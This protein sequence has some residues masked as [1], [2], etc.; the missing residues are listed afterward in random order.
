MTI[1][2]L[3]DAIEKA[4]TILTTTLEG[5]VR[6]QGYD[7]PSPELVKE[8]TSIDYAKFRKEL[9]YDE[10]EL[11]QKTIINGFYCL[12]VYLEGRP[13]AFDYGYDDSDDR[14]FFSDTEATMIERKGIGRLLGILE[15]LY[16]YEKGYRAVKFMTEEMDECGRP[17]REIWEKQGYMVANRYPDGGVDMILEITPDIVA[18]RVEKN[19]R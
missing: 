19:L 15:L 10:H 6:I 13:I 1:P 11:G 3:S 5:E 16:L 4:E 8:I 9:Q 2:S 12:M 14:V 17:L 18:E 7:N